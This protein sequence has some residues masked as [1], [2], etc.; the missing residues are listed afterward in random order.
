MRKIRPSFPRRR[1]LLATPFQPLSEADFLRLVSDGLAIP[2]QQ[3]GSLIVAKWRDRPGMD[4][5]AFLTALKARGLSL[6]VRRAREDVNVRVVRGKRAGDARPPAPDR[7]S[8][9]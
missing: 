2:G 6:E 9:R 7:E 1:E 3:G 8:P 5:Q 4:P